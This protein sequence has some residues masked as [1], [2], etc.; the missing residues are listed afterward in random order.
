L[1]RLQEFVISSLKWTLSKDASQTRLANSKLGL[2]V[3]WLT[4]YMCSQLHL[5]M[6]L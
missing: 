4:C 6:I 5:K 3:L 1:H 2:H